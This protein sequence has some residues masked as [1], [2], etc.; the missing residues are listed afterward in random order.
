MQL[1]KLLTPINL[2]VMFAFGVAWFIGYRN[3][4]VV[5]GGFA[6]CS[7]ASLSPQYKAERGLW[8]AGAVLLCLSLPMVIGG[9]AMVLAFDGKEKGLHVLL[10]SDIA[11]WLISIATFCFIA[12]ASVKNY[13]LQP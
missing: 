6:A 3:F 7:F 10:S 1:S 5:T 2:F 8:M 13:Q 12:Y 4:F 9:L 11:G